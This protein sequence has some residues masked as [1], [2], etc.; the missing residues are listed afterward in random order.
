MNKFEIDPTLLRNLKVNTPAG[1]GVDALALEN[2]AIQDNLEKEQI[3]PAQA[4]HMQKQLKLMNLLYIV[5]ANK[6][7][8]GVPRGPQRY[9][10][11]GGNMST[12]MKQKGY[13]FKP[14][15]E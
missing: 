6:G 3:T 5:A 9:G 13:V 11:Y 15:G 14:I 10:R 12:K 1:S 4:K 2:A 8:K 7:G